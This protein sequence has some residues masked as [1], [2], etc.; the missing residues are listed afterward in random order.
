MYPS[1]KGKKRYAVTP[2][3]VQFNGQHIAMSNSPTHPCAGQRF[4]E[5]LAVLGE[6]LNSSILAYYPIIEAQSG[7]D[8]EVN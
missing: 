4:R 3:I 1:H 8:R 2:F 5:A 6:F 7:L